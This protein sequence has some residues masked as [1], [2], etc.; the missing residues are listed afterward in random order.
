MCAKIKCDA[1]KKISRHPER[2]QGERKEAH[3]AHLRISRHRST[4]AGW[5]PNG[6]GPA[7]WLLRGLL[8][9]PWVCC[10]GGAG[11]GFLSFSSAAE[12]CFAPLVYSEAF[13]ES[14]SAAWKNGRR[15][16]IDKK[17]PRKWRRVT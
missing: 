14:N 11:G 8:L 9:V 1:R 15:K 7:K 6:E 2:Q 13:E 17:M 3:T 10:C 12:H 4:L 16:R 5:D